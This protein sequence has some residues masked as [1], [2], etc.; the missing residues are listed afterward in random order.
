MSAKNSFTPQEKEALIIFLMAK[1]NKQP[2][3]PLKTT[4]EIYKSTVQKLGAVVETLPSPPK[5]AEWKRDPRY[6]KLVAEGYPLPK[7]KR[8]FEIICYARPDF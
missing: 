6:L 5:R 2:D 1:G 4:P 8:S 3:K 7:T